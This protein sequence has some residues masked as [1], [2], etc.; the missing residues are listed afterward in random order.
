MKT[1][2]IKSAPL[3]REPETPSLRSR[4]TNDRAV[5]AL[6]LGLAA[7]LVV[8]LVLLA[9]TWSG[10]ADRRALDDAESDALAAAK[11]SAVAMTTYDHSRL[12]QDFAWVDKGATPGFASQYR[13]A[14]K[15]LRGIIEKLKASATGKVSEAAATADSASSV[16]VVMFIDQRISNETNKQARSDKSRVIM[17][18][19]K[20][21]RIWLVDDVELR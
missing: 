8:A 4:A 1:L 18:M 3:K 9:V 19:V 5:L 12:D 10:A 14:N 7:A 13:D 2:T 11:S 20:R 6:L 17:S 21:D 15:P 16:R